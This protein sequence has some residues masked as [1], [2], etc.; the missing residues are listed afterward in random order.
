MEQSCEQTAPSL[1]GQ[2]QDQAPATADIMDDYDGDVQVV[3]NSFRDYGG[4]SRFCGRVE[5]VKCF[6][7]NP[8][9]R[10]RLTKEDGA[11][12]VLVVDGGGSL[13]R[14]L[15]GDQLAA[16]GL[17]NGWRGVIINGAVRDSS[18]IGK[19]PF[20]CKALGT[21][22][23]KSEKKVPG[24]QGV[25]VEFGGLRFKAGQFVYAD[26]DGIVVSDEPLRVPRDRSAL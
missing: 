22:P 11:G 1:K 26:E 12:K 8:L 13:R 7:N 5:T 17:Q 14:A 15:M 19:L 9:V 6:E 2:V 23:R 16:G 25:P 4:V 20:G 18:E 24:E 10:Q 21:M 3:T